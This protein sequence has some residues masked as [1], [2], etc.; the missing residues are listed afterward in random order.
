[1]NIFV[2]GTKNYKLSVRALFFIFFALFIF[3][4]FFCVFRVSL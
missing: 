1:M 4:L 3:V 2:L